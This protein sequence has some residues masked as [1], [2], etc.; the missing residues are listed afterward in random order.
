MR[1]PR[2]NV[3]IRWSAEVLLGHKAFFKKKK[4]KKKLGKKK[5]KQSTSTKNAQRLSSK[6]RWT[7]STTVLQYEV[8]H[9]V[10]W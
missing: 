1:G 8:Q 5:R 3:H 9:K 4:K 7:W 2:E 10:R 6:G